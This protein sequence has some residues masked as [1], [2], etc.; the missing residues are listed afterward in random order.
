[1]LCEIWV[2]LFINIYIYSLEDAYA[3]TNK[4]KNSQSN[5]IFG[6]SKEEFGR[7][8]YIKDINF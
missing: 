3:L 6:G 4:K 5:W 7:K 1:M 2:A 8:K